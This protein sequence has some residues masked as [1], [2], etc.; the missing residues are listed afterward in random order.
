VDQVPN[1]FSGKV[2]IVTGAG[3]VI[4]RAVA[5]ELAAS[6]MSIGCLS[7]SEPGVQE[8][9]RQVLEAG[10]VAQSWLA[11][12]TDFAQVQNAVAAAH[13]RFGRLDLLVNV[14]GRFHCIAPAWEASP[15]LWRADVEV[16]LT[17]TFHMCRAV[18]PVMRR[19]GFGCVVNLDG[20][21]GANG[22]NAGGSAYGS[23][24]AAIV[25]FTETVAR[26]LQLDGS[27]V[28]IVAMNPGFMRSP[29]TERAAR[30]PWQARVQ[31]RLHAA[32][33]RPPEAFARTLL[34][35]LE[36]MHADFN[37][38]TFDAEVD[39]RKLAA[40]RRTIV[41]REVYLMRTRPLPHPLWRRM[42]RRG[43]RWIGRLLGRRQ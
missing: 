37:G 31:R 29:M 26:E 27:G 5:R 33:V 1:T 19:Q 14:A 22:A 16:N 43:G 17:G 23:S 42:R 8:T 7:A 21:G 13:Q 38:R 34:A 32:R 35:L 20:G 12:V 3:G 18:L 36:V 30:S 41:A 11:D 24:K 2:A 40:K 15:E 6:G 10:G 28:I 25:R 39:P 9:Q 4:G